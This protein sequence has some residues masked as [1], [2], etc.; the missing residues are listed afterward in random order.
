MGRTMVTFD[1]A[2]NDDLVLE[3]NGYKKP[4]DVRRLSINGIVDTGATK[5]VVSRKVAEALG[6]TMKGQ[7]TV[8]Y[9]DSRKAV[10]DIMGDIE[11]T[12]MGRKGRFTAVIEEDRPDALIGAIVLEELDLLV[13]SAKHCLVPRQSDMIFAELE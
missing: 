1:V 4:E 5:L 11:V 10:R 3:S 9:A 8:K 2:S 13:D 7:A 6:L 12:I